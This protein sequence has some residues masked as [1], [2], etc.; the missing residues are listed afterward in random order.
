M[1]KIILLLLFLFNFY[2]Y[3]QY[4]KTHYIAPA[5]WQYWSKANEIVIGTLST[6]A[7][8]NVTLKKSDGTVIADNIQVT[9]NNPISYI[10]YPN[11]NIF[12]LT[13]N[14]LNTVYNDR[15]L[16]VEATEPVL[17][18]LRNIDSDLGA[19]SASLIKGNASLVSFG[20]EG[21]GLNFRVGYYRSSTAGLDSGG[22]VYSV[23]AT[24]DN[25]NVTLPSTTIILNKGQSYLFTAPIGALVSA[26]KVVVMN[27]GSYGDTPMTCGTNGQDGTFDQIAPV[28]SLGTKYMVVRGEGTAPTASQIPLGY[29][30]EQTTI[31]A[32]QPNTTLTINNFNANGSA[33]GTTINQTLATAGA[34][35]T[36]YH[37]NGTSLFS[38]SIINSTNPVI[39]YSG[40]AVGCET[41]ISTVL[42]IGGCAGAMNI[43][44][45]KFIN[46]VN[47]DLPYFGFSVIE[48]ATTP[49]LINNQNIEVLTG[50]PR[51]PIGATGLYLI[52]FNNSQINNP[53]N[54]IITSTLPVTSSLVQQ[55]DGFSMS[56]F[57]SSF[58]EVAESPVIA[59]TNSNC[60]VTL[61]A[62][63]GFTQ[64]IWFLNGAQH[65]TT[66]TN[67]LLVTQSGNY[68]VQVMKPCGLSGISVPLEVTV[69]P[70]VDLSIDKETISQNN[71]D[72]TF[73][74]TVKNLNPYFTESQARVTDL[75]PTGYTYTSY[76]ASIGVYNASTG[77]W[78]IGSLAPNHTETLVIN[79]K[80]NDTGDYINKASITGLLEES[81]SNNNQDTATILSLMADLD[82]TK[83]DSR[84]MYK[85]G[86]ILNYTIKVINKGPN[87]AL[88]VNVSDPMPHN[89]TEMSWSGNNKSGNGDLSDVIDI[90][91]PDVEVIYN[92]TLKVPTNHRGLFTNEVYVS[93]DFIIDPNPICT[94]CMDTNLEEFVIPK[95]ISPNNDGSNDYLDL[96]DY[97]ISKLI[98]Y[99]R[100][101]T[102]VYTKSDY[103]NQWHGQDNKDNLL[104]TGTYYYEIQ[105]LNK[106]YKTGYIYLMRE[107]K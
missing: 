28:H 39:V 10:F 37:G 83:D 85:P 69:N 78:N 75:L 96:S 5:P 49:V 27:V 41:D 72:V 22:P 59:Q 94:D 16:I 2:S 18:N 23:M 74:I 13:K 6:A 77:I 52:T 68:S 82:A 73:E 93:S 24:E 81:N 36:F 26:D 86:D 19:N 64:Y 46:F 97:F 105:V 51:V 62:E 80:I 21:M 57:F 50:V 30:S 98:I 92:V 44:T 65:Q 102:E 61:Q 90:L 99:N 84:E 70:C 9:V 63:T 15:G 40:T 48:S 60:T 35:Y 71:L 32:T 89:V 12:S 43:Q 14:N 29:G 67:S 38:S 107:I 88:Q 104:P 101:G 34:S 58:G 1:K 7:S 76:N 66:T 106:N 25:T 33:S 45:K 47:N 42:P 95:G 103:K 79:C 31:V 53:S 100:Y 87:K 3:G 17:V 4:Y 54:L 56:A 8:V 91:E 20:A 55:G 11:E